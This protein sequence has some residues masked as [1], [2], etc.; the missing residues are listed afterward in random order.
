MSE[1]AAQRLVKREVRK[2]DRVDVSVQHL[3]AEVLAL[4]QVV[5]D[6]SLV[7]PVGLA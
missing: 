4:A 1:E 5:A 2:V 7:E 6:G 3:L